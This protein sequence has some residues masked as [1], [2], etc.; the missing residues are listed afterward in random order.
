MS[1]SVSASSALL[2][3]Q[4]APR[5]VVLEG[6]KG[7]GKTTLLGR[8]NQRLT[9]AGITATLLCPTRPMSAWHPL[10]QTFSDN[11]QQNDLFL[12]RL[13]AARSNFHAGALDPQARLIL[14]DRSLLTSWATR[15]PESDA[16]NWQH[17]CE[18]VR[19]RE[20]RIPLPDLVLFLDVPLASLQKRLAARGE[21]DYGRH[22]ETGERLLAAR[23][24]YRAIQARL[25]QLS[26]TTRWVDIDADA[27]PV[28]VEQ[29][30]WQVLVQ[31]G[32]LMNMVG[33]RA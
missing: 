26:P 14:G 12:Q 17:Y 28:H 9:R 15:W 20:W 24:A 4:P 5:Y 2:V 16:D 21:R 31:T 8:L 29:A 18:A 30:A 19:R 1:L 6:L 23:R 10:E 11:P 27:D 7:S 22:D 33:E 32:V 3:P 13:Y 25:P